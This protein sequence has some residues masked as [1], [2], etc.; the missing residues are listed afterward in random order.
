MREAFFTTVSK[1][2]SYNH[3]RFGALYRSVWDTHNGEL[4]KN[5][6][7]SFQKTSLG[8][9]ITPIYMRKLPKGELDKD[10]TIIELDDIQDRRGRIKTERIVSEIGSDK[11]V[12][13]NAD[14]LFSRLRPYL[15]KVVLNDK[16]KNY[17]GTTEL[18]A[19]KLTDKAIPEYVKYLLISSQLIKLSSLL[20]Y[21]K[22]H[23]RLDQ[24]DLLRILVPSPPRIIQKKIVK[25]IT[26][27]VEDRVNILTLKYVDL[28]NAIHN[29]FQEFEIHQ[30]SNIPSL[31]FYKTAFASIGNL[32]ISLNF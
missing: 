27:K 3:Y 15:G 17:I 23:P 6:P 19:F 1:I 4:F 5:I 30:D 9:L 7:I 2:T 31:Q 29:I 25:D 11:C 13:G 26:H 12:F 14:I 32:K 22:Q 28:Q 16:S 24:E 10:Y 21:G 18:L 20:M 8:N